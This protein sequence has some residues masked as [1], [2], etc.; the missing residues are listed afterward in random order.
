MAVPTQAEEQLIAAMRASPVTE[1]K[2][3]ELRHELSVRD[4]YSLVTFAARLAVHAVRIGDA[5]QL[6][7]VLPMLIVDDCVVDW[8]DILVAMAIIEDC[9]IR[10]G[11][12]FAACVQNVTQFATVRRRRTIEEGYLSRPRTRREVEVMGYRAVGVD[13]ELTYVRRR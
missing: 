9:A 4:A 6:E 8:R 5:S 1:I 3:V 12:D 13:K 2:V 7:I 11:I 10:L